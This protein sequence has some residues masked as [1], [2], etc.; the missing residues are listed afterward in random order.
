[1]MLEILTIYDYYPTDSLILEASSPR[2]VWEEATSRARYE[3]KRD[4]GVSFIYRLNAKY[5]RVE[6]IA[7][8]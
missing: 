4:N 2:D 1:M 6:C 5:E 8:I 7:H 3:R